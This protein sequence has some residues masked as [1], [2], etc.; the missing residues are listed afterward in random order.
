[1]IFISKVLDFIAPR[2]CVSCNK[3]LIISDQFICKLCFIKATELTEQE[4]KSEYERKFRDSNFIHNYTSLFKFEKDGNIQDLI[5]ALKYN[6]KFKIGIFLGRII[7]NKKKEILES[8]QIDLIIPIPLHHLK[9][10]ERGYNQAEYIGKGLSNSLGIKLDTSIA[11]RIKDTQ[12]QTKLNTNERV[13]NMNEAFAVKN[14]KEIVGKNILIV[15]DVITTGIT[16]IEL[17]KKLKE[18]GAAKVF[19]L[20]IATPLISHTIGS[21]NA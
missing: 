21:S 15:D 4:I 12:S 14:S 1:M 7:G 18:N 8:W 6:Q 13:E 20:S 2:F 19:C 10:I 11:K 5:H 16:V 9:K 3:K 17:A